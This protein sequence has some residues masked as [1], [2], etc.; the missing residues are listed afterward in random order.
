MS[1]LFGGNQTA[2]NTNTAVS[3]INVQQSVYGAVINLVYGTNRVAGN[4]MW[5]GNFISTANNS[6]SSSGG[7]GGGGSSNG[8]TTY[9]YTA[10]VQV[11]LCEGP[12]QDI[13][14]VWAGQSVYSGLNSGSSPLG[15]SLFNGANP[16]TPWGWQTTSD[17][18]E[19]LGYNGTAYVAGATV[20]L[21]SSASLPAFNFEVSSNFQFGQGVID[22][23]PAVVVAD[24][25][26][27][28]TYGAGFPTS[29]LGSLTQFSNYCIANG[30]FISPAYAAQDSAANM[31]SEIFTVAN[32]EA[33]MSEGV[34][35]VVPYD[36]TP[37][38][39]YG[40]TYTPNNQVLYSLDDD[41]F[42]YDSSTDPVVCTR[43]DQ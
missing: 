26:T 19:A 2:A 15:L 29:M 34:L 17:A 13:G 8:P 3:G 7:K 39:N 42:I 14:Q 12:I 30:I 4:L 43:A 33:F 41:D 28:P 10:A 22:E 1:G 16:Q 6:N 24:L 20:A 36:D 21:D 5:Y 18:S 11:G 38:S 25:L 23:N 32:C 37:A 40:V 9:T 31:L 27:N 35:K